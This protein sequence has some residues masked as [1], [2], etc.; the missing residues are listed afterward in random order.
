LTETLSD[1]LRARKLLLV[2]DNC[3]HLIEACAIL[4]EVL[5][6]ACPDLKILATSREA[7]AV[8][9]EVTWPVP[10]L[11][12]PDPRHPSAI[13]E[14]R[15]YEAVRLFSERAKA[16]S[17]TFEFGPKNAPAVVR[18]CE[19]LEGMPL[20]IELAAAKVRVLSVEQI[21]ARLDRSIELLKSESRTADPRQRTLR[22]TIE[23]S[24]DLLSEQ[25]R[26]LFRRLSAFVGGWT[27]EAA[28]EVC[29]GGSIEKDEVLDQLTHLVDKS[30]VLVVA[31]H[32]GGE[33]RYRLLETIRQAGA[34]KLEA[35]G[36]DLEV[37][38]RHAEFFLALA[39]G[40]E[41]AMWGAEEVAWLR[42]LEAEQDN[43][44]AALSWAIDRDA[45]LGLR[46]AAALR[47][48]WYW[49][50]HY[51]EGRRWLDEA[52]V[53]DG[54]TSVR[55]RALHAAGWLAHD[56]GDMTRVE[57][58]A[59]EGVELSNN[60]GI[61]DSLSASFRNLLGVA[62]RHR[63]DYQQAMELFEGG[64]ALY[65]AAGD[66]RG[67]A[68]GLFLSG[69]ASSLRGD[70]ERAKAL[71]QEGLAQCR[72]L[73]GAQPLGDYLSHMGYEF[74]LEGDYPRAAALNEEAATLL[75]S[76]G[77]RGGLQFA[78]NNLGWIALVRGTRER[79]SAMF[80]ESLV[81]CRELGDGLIASE[82]VEGLAC[83][84]GARGAERAARLFGAAMA[85]RDAVGYRQ[86]SRHSALRE[87]YLEDARSRLD[88]ETWDAA[89]AE[90]R[91]MALAVAIEYALSEN[92]PTSPVEPALTSEARLVTVE[93]EGSKSP[94]ELRVLALG[95]ERIELE[96]RILVSSEFGYA[97]PREL[98]FYLLDNP[99]RTREQ[100]GL[101]LW[102]E[103]SASRLRGSFHDALYRLR[104]ALGKPEWVVHS[105]GRYS[106]NPSLAHFFDVR[107]FESNLATAQQLGEQAPAEA[108]GH[109]QEAVKLYAGDFLEDF[110]NSEWVLVR[111]EELGGSYQE[112]LMALARLLLEKERIAEAAEAYRKVVLR[113]RYSDAAH[114]ELM[115]CYARLGELGRALKHYEGLVELLHQELG[116]QPSLETVELY[117]RL[118]RGD[119][120]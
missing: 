116:A 73:G 5:L 91:T 16:A 98:L 50:G 84:A 46:L 72:E 25:E 75:R 86:S 20:A 99:S 31:Q 43:L 44:R 106:I 42:R 57:K 110:L 62:A 10:A 33:A 3:E 32:G 90:G 89:F 28:E 45:E 74:L 119:E 96:G 118:L 19:R 120:V 65:R 79:A 103:A 117:E 107:A 70:H 39:E 4:A 101:A 87:P 23:W 94:M 41:P 27:L 67:V 60:A 100:V 77:Y 26:S 61:E 9:G 54:H 48:F 35:S 34:E 71:F 82:S 85:L 112:A 11:S 95:Q 14:L 29:V 24:H 81:L 108:I 68:W 63:G 7:L 37:R 115:R 18:V 36:E 51:G 93:T 104:K 38:R 102:P 97:K 80:E 113:D 15:R 59:E 52:L 109:L 21:A 58:A 22:A 8:T 6:R 105:A 2:L 114:R 47:W 88:A 111:Q 83:A 1:H 76:Q 55:A 69:N 40:L 64:T 13:E 56:Q 78:L 17:P 30:L 66:K 92:E 49:R 12:L 53:K